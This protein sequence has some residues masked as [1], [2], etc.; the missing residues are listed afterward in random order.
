M[1]RND[2][3]IDVLQEYSPAL[4]N[5]PVDVGDDSVLVELTV[6]LEAAAKR[7]W[8][9]PSSGRATSSAVRAPP[10][11]AEVD[12][13]DEDEDE[14]EVVEVPSSTG[15]RLHREREVS[16][17]ISTTNLSKP[18]ARRLEMHLEAGLSA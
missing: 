3:L 7:L 4:I 1:A 2:R 10:P 15:Q 8:R 14:L 5:S 13:L 17:K 9:R 6:R 16:Q 11:V 12:T 18:T